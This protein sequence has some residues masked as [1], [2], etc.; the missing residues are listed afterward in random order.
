MYLS[1]LNPFLWKYLKFTIKSNC[2]NVEAPDEAQGQKRSPEKKDSKTGG[3]ILGLTAL[4]DSVVRGD[5]FQH[6]VNV[7]S[8]SGPAIWILRLPTEN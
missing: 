3:G 2:V 1:L 8:P 5:R 4:A 7:P 6:L